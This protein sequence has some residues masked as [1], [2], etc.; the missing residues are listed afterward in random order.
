MVSG[1]ESGDSPPTY[2][3]LCPSQQVS[4]VMP[5]T[6]VVVLMSFVYQSF[7]IVMTFCD[8]KKLETFSFQNTFQLNFE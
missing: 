3:T 1:V 5:I 7:T 6:H 4:S 8:L 2:N